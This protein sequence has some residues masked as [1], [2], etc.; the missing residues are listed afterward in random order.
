MRSFA[1]PAALT[2]LAIAAP[3]AEAF[4][5][6]NGGFVVARGATTAYVT[7]LTPSG[8]LRRTLEAGFDAQWA[9]D[10]KRIAFIAFRGPGQLT[11][12]RSDGTGRHRIVL[13][14]E[15]GDPA[16]L[17][18]SWSPGGTRI[19]FVRPTRSGEEPPFALS[20]V[21]PSGHK[22]R[23]VYTT[24][25]GHYID[26]PAWSPDGKLI[27][28]SRTASRI[29]V[30]GADGTGRHVLYKSTGGSA[31]NSP[32]W[33]PDGTKIAFDTEGSADPQVMVMNAD[34]SGA[35]AIAH[36]RRPSWSPDGTKIAFITRGSRLATFTVATN[37]FARIGHLNY[38]SDVDW[39]R[40]PG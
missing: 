31:A 40:R 30:I 16:P 26:A 18:P 19:A 10:G 14:K 32:V 39:Q 4:P 1:L 34:G 15:R 28:F 35:H 17:T 25:R 8:S 2:A 6:V 11:V 36:G 29:E 13:P 21:S 23:T 12:V 37:A 9:P 5:G 27:A 22:L 38:I 20:V 7:T 33:S 3:A 24:R